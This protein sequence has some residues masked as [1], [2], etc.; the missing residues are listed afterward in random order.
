MTPKLARALGSATKARPAP[1]S[2]VHK[3]IH[4]EPPQHLQRETPQR[5]II[6]NR[7]ARRIGGGD[8]HNP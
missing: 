4:L 5:P 6:Q 2:A 8:K 7:V 1:E 3:T